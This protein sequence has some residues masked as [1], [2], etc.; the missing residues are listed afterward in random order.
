MLR[1]LATL[2]AVGALLGAPTAT[3]APNPAAG[4][5][6]GTLTIPRLA[7]ETDVIQGTGVRELARGVGHYRISALPGQRRTVAIA[8][9]RTTYGRPFQSLNRLRAGD[10]VVFTLWQG[11]RYVYE[12]TGARVVAF[13]DWSILANKGYDKLV[14]TTCHPPGSATQRLAVFARL[15]VSR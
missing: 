7:L 5:R 15:R 4:F 3:A 9:H 8:G 10:R 6:L 14:L 11:R 1:L 12:V 13:N 2:T